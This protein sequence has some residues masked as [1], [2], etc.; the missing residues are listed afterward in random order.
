MI[1]SKNKFLPPL[2]I[3]KCKIT[4]LECFAILQRAGCYGQLLLIFKSMTSH[5]HT[6]RG[7]VLSAWMSSGWM[8]EGWTEVRLEPCEVLRKRMQTTG[9]WTHIVYIGKQ[10][11]TEHGGYIA[12]G[13]WSPVPGGGGRVALWFLQ[14][15]KENKNQKLVETRQLPTAPAARGNAR[16]REGFG[17]H[18]LVMGVGL[19]SWRAFVP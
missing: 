10:I 18:L 11:G 3:R 6:T 14:K 16:G 4:Y 19:E 8:G 9:R 12:D 7:C 1:Q 15:W 2:Y 13:Q 5:L 17:F